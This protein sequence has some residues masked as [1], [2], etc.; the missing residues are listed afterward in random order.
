MSK[1]IIPANLRWMWPVFRL[2]QRIGSPEKAARTL[3]Y[4]A[5]APEAANMT[6]HYFESSTRPKK[7]GPALLNQAKQDKAWELAASLVRKPQQR[8]LFLRW[9]WVLLH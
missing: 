1:N 4:L 5:S 9:G 2:I 7:L 6:G 3:I 8:F